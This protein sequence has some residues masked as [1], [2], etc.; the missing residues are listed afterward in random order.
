MH[1]CLDG[2]HL[3]HRFKEIPAWLFMFP[4]F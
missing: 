3:V 1:P 2:F 4:R